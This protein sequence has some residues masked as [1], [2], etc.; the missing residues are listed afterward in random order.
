MPDTHDYDDYVTEVEIKTKQERADAPFTCILTNLT[1]D[2]DPEWAS[3]EDKKLLP[4][5]W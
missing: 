3:E 5:G 1:D 4:E 2:P